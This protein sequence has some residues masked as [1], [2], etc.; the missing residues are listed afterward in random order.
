MLDVIVSTAQPLVT[1]DDTEAVISF[2]PGGQAANVA[3]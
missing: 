1:D 3:A 2:A